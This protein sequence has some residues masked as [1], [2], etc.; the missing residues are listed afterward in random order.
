MEALD[1]LE[2]VD[3]YFPAEIDPSGD[4][5]AARYI[6]ASDVDGAYHHLAFSNG[7]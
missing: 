7:R 2:A 3:L 5:L 4:S 1:Y 6:E